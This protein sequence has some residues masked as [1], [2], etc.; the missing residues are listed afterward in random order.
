MT[1][2][3]IRLRR[4][5]DDLLARLPVLARPG[6]ARFE[7]ATTAHEGRVAL[8]VHCARGLSFTEY[9]HP[10]SSPSV[11]GPSSGQPDIDLD[12]WI[13]FQ[14]LIN[15]TV[16]FGKLGECCQL[17]VS[18]LALNVERQTNVTKS[19]RGLLVDAKSAFEI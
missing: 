19:N 2:R 16:A 11:N 17:F 3:S 7:H 9:R 5:A 8:G 18:Q 10:V 6:K 14:R 13:G 12:G 1:T 15:D 4:S